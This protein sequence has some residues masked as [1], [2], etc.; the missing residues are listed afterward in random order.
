VNQKFYLEQDIMDME[1]IGIFDSV[2]GHFKEIAERK[3]KME[4]ALNEL[5]V[6]LKNL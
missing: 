4:I 6:K 2:D 5:D 1:A 3:I